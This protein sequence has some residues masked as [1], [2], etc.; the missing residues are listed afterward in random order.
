[1][2]EPKDKVK[3]D[4][5]KLDALLKK[6]SDLKAMKFVGHKAKPTAEQELDVDQGRV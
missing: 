3:I 2:V 5:E 1:M 4:V 6:L